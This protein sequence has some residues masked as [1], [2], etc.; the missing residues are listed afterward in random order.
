MYIYIIEYDNCE[1]FEDHCTWHSNKVFE[2]K[3][4]AIRFLIGEGFNVPE[5]INNDDVSF[6]KYFDNG[7]MYE[8]EIAEIEYVKD[9]FK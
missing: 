7:S 8:A 5:G 3:M 4:Q 2:T 6:Y 1:A 9:N